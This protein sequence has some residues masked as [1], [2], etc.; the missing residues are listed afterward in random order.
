MSG[1]NKLTVV[2]LNAGPQMDR[3]LLA[4]RRA[5]LAGAVEAGDMPTAEQLA[6]WMDAATHV[7]RVQAALVSETVASRIIAESYAAIVESKTYVGFPCVG[8][9]G[10][11]KRV[12]SLDEFCEVFFGKSARR[13][14]QLAANLDT[15]GADLYEAG[16]RIGLGQRDYN[17]LRALPAD[18]QAVVKAALAEGSDK[19]AV[20]DLLNELASRLQ[21]AKAE[22]EVM[23]RRARDQIARN[24]ELSEKLSDAMHFWRQAEPNEQAERLLNELYVTARQLAVMMVTADPM[25]ESLRSRIVAVREHAAANGNESEHDVFLTG[26]IAQLIRYLDRMRSEMDLPEVATGSPALEAAVA[27]GALETLA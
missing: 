3:D 24:N 16:E 22:K 19:S 5:F 14:Q 20:L 12:S 9:D 15:L 8:P 6:G 1:R 13:C 27:L 10:S 2:P 7:G 11:A 17:A 18:D 21:E 23:D 25:V 4:E 26:V